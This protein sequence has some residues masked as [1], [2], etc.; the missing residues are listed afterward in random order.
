MIEDI[1]IEMACLYR[2]AEAKVA[3]KMAAEQKG[4]AFDDHREALHD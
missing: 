2:E 3:A 4:E 1:E